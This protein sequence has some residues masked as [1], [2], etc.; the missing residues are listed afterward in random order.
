MARPL[1]AAR[2]FS[3]KKRKRRKKR[4]SPGREV[5][6]ANNAWANTAHKILSK[7]INRELTGLGELNEWLASGP[8][9]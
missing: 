9:P 3:R 8:D 4:L 5:C 1:A 2:L 6:L 7:I